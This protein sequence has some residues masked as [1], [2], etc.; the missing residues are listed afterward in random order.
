MA[1][2]RVASHGDVDR[3][4]HGNG[5]FMNHRPLDHDHLRRRSGEQGDRQLERR[6]GER[7][8]R[9]HL[10]GHLELRLDADR[11]VARRTEEREERAGRAECGGRAAGEAGER[12][13]HG[14][15]EGNDEGQAAKNT[16]G[17]G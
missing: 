9:H 16:A 14:S 11:V 12:A 8:Q 10:L 3:N 15:S 13:G 6:A 1:A 5:H 2:A 7:A 17:A 4:R